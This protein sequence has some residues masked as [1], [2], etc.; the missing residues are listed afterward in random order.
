M[1]T[2]TAGLSLLIVAAASDVGFPTSSGQT[3]L[4]SG[5]SKNDLQICKFV[6]DV[7]KLEP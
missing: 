3:Y 1:R 5:N 2:V 6:F 4:N 7:Y